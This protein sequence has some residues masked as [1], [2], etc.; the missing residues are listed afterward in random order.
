MLI[1]SVI[2]FFLCWLPYHGY[3]LA[4]WIIPQINYWEHIQEMY[5]GV[6]WLAMSSSMHNPVIYCI[7]NAKYELFSRHDVAKQST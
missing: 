5:L 3:F 6:F 4:S 7:M 2:T 1:V